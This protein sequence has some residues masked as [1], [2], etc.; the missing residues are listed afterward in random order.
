MGEFL[1][2]CVGVL[3]VSIKKRTFSTAFLFFPDDSCHGV[4]V[5]TLASQV[6]PIGRTYGSEAVEKEVHLL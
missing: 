4:L 3:A 5:L 1:V 2:V 6:F